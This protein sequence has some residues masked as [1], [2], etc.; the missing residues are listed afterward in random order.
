MASNG[1]QDRLRLWYHQPAGS[2]FT[3]AIPV[4]N[5]YM[6]AMVYGNVPLERIS[7][8]EGTFWSGGPGDNNNPGSAGYLEQARELLFSGR[9]REAEE[10]VTQHMM[11]GPECAF[12]PAGCLLL[13]FDGHDDPQDYCRSLDL[14]TAIARVSYRAGRV[15]YTRETYASHPDR[16]L[17]I[18]LTA[19]REKS[20]GF[21]AG[22]EHKLADASVSTACG[23]DLLFDARGEDWRGMTGCVRLQARVHI[24]QQGGT[25]HADGQQIQVDRADSVTLYLTI[26]TNYINAQ[27]LSGHPAAAN[28][29]ILARLTAKTETQIRSDHIEDHQKLFNRVDINLGQ[30]QSCAHLPV[31]ERIEGYTRNRDH[32][33]VALYYQFC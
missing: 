8:N 6:G 30:V 2:Q 26:S 25:I 12:M 28:Q 14:E 21:T 15:C 31:D 33:L 20:I 3:R 5:G 17:I 24:S 23:T 11:G 22:Y 18:R 7:L 1:K 10:I 16:A 19:D 13:N 9:Y 4:G 32:G 27:D 29:R